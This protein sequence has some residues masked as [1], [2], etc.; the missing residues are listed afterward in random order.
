MVVSECEIP[1][2]FK[3]NSVFEYWEMRY[4]LINNLNPDSYNAESINPQIVYFKDHKDAV[5]F[6]LMWGN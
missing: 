4:W 2:L 3:I 5:W 6:S 1:V